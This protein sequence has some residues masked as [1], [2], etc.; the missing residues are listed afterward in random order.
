M[1]KLELGCCISQRERDA[2]DQPHSSFRWQESH[3]LDGKSKSKQSLRT[4]KDDQYQDACKE[5]HGLELQ[6]R[7]CV[8]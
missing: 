8:A 3:L 2:T 6:G 5:Y 7:G 1:T 4:G